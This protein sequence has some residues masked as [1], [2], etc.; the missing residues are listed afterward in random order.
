MD[1]ETKANFTRHIQKLTETALTCADQERK[2]DAVRSLMCMALLRA[3][4]DHPN[5]AGSMTPLIEKAVLLL[6]ETPGSL[7]RH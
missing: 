4:E 3:P 2:D 5:Y 1:R 7:S 6:G